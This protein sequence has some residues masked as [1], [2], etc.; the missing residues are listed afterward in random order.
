MTEDQKKAAIERLAKAREARKKAPS[1]LKNV[2]ADVA[3]LPDDHALSYVN[4]KLYL[5]AC[6]EQLKAARSDMRRNVKGASSLYY[7][8]K[9][10]EGNI[11]TYIRNGDWLDDFY[12]EEHSKKIQWRVTR[13]AYHDNGK[14]KRQIGLHYPDYNCVWTAELE[15]EELA[16]YGIVKKK[17]PTPVKSKKR[18]AVKSK[19]K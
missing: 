12:G 3:A 16:A 17:A 2:H 14:P 11:N 1:E 7:R 13:M 19:A 8:W 9:G 5:K 18:R 6:K 15:A 10:Y 4:C